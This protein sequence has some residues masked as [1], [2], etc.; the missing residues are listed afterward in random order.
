MLI[1]AAPDAIAAWSGQKWTVASQHH[2]AA[3]SEKAGFAAAKR[4]SG[5]VNIGSKRPLFG[6]EHKTTVFELFKGFPATF[7]VIRRVSGERKGRKRKENFWDWNL[8][9]V[10]I[11]EYKVEYSCILWWGTVVLL[12]LTLVLCLQ[13]LQLF[14]GFYG[15]CLTILSFF[16][17]FLQN[18]LTVLLS[19][20]I[21]TCGFYYEYFINLE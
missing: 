9:V 6:S 18:L 19:N 4:C 17:F 11:S 16:N 5:A 1:A 15:T 21:K 14:C 7:E 3:R 2:C 10:F 12:L 20:F 13:S 8:T